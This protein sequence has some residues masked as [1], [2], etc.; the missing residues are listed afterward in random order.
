VNRRF[1]LVVGLTMIYGID[2]CRGGWVVAKSDLTLSDI[3][4]ELTEDLN[5][6]LRQNRDAT[7]AIDIPI[8]L[9]DGG[10]RRCDEEARQFLGVRRSSVFFPPVRPTLL[11]G[12]HAQAVPINRAETGVGISLQAFC[13]MHKIREVDEFMRPEMQTFIREVHPE[14]SFASLNN[15]LPMR[16]DKHTS[17]GRTERLSVLKR[18]KLAISDAWLKDRRHEL[19]NTKVVKLDDL[20]DALACLVSAWHIHSGLYRSLGQPVQLDSKGLVMEIAACLPSNAT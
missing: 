12:T 9:A 14:V 8:G 10:R 5:I 19:G 17:P 1:G 18:H 7:I 11:A 6:L 15:G 2:G 4:F 3:T 13:I 20:V 16:L